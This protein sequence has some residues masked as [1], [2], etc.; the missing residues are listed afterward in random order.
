MS[1]AK[2]L[3]PRLLR[4]ASIVGVTTLAILS[5]LPGDLRPSTGAGRTLEHATAYLV[6]ATVLAAACPARARILP[7]LTLVVLAA[8]LEIG[9]LWIPGR[10]AT[11][12]DL[13][14]S[15]AGAVSGW[16]IAKLVLPRLANGGGAVSSS[17]D[18]RE[19][20]SARS[21]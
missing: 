20:A 1:V 5:W 15:S 14:A 12:R 2:L 3:N 4:A 6:M 7:V 21:G 16:V 10:D 8:V 18:V 9:Q 13:L 19:R 17:Q 11:V